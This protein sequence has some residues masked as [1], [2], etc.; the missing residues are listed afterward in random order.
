MIFNTMVHAPISHPEKKCGLKAIFKI[1]GYLCWISSGP[2]IL[3]LPILPE[4]Y[5]LK[6]KVVLKWRDIYTEN[7]S[8][9]SVMARLKMEGTV[10]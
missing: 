3:K 1:E 2:C 9:V 8:T 10:K 5:G 6:L 4:K 7:I